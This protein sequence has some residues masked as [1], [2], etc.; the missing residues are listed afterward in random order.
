[1]ERALEMAGD[2]EEKEKLYRVLRRIDERLSLLDRNVD[3]VRAE[4]RTRIDALRLELSEDFETTLKMEVSGSRMALLA[5][6]E[7]LEAEMAE[8]RAGKPPA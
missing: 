2:G 3:L 1:M 6:I 7:T 4:M 8:L 5:R